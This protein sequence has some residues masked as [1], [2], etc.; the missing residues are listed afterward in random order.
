MASRKRAQAQSVY[1][2]KITLKDC[3]PPI[4][5]R[6]QGRSDTTLAQLHWVI[7][8]SMGWTNSHLH[9]FTIQ[10]IEYGV[11][12]PEFDFDDME[13]LDERSVQL[14]TVIP[15][16]KFKFSYLYDFGDSWE[17]DILVE[18]VL[19]ADPEISYPICIKAQ[20]ACPPEDCGGVWGYRNFLEAIQDPDHPEHD[21]LLEWVGGSFD[22]EDA[23]FDE[24]N[25]LL[26]RIPKNTT[27]FEG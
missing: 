9:S 2:L 25:P 23:D 4:W 24:I 20:R 8:F 26:K 15:G 5:R 21:E 14:S 19:E 11:P 18:K 3:R 7:Q 16:E 12:M 10:G 22:P 27:H 6:V 1:Q 17:H 13:V